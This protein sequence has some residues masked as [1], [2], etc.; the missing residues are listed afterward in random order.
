MTASKPAR[1]CSTSA[2]TRPRKPARKRS[3]AALIQS[4]RAVTACSLRLR[5]RC[6]WPARSPTTSERRG[7][8]RSPRATASSA[9]VRSPSASV[10]R[11]DVDVAAREVAG[12]DPAGGAAFAEAD[13]EAHGV[14]LHGLRRVLLLL[15]ARVAALRHPDV[16]DP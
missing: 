5:P 7:P 4:R 9:C 2:P 8:T 15:P 10:V 16:A 14:F 3:T 13:A 6:A 12:P 11:V 1:P